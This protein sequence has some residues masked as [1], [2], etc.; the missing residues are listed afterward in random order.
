MVCRLK[1]LI[2]QLIA[3]SQWESFPPSKPP[4]SHTRVVSTQVDPPRNV[5][6]SLVFA[7][8]DFRSIP[9]INELY[10]GAI[11]ERNMRSVLSEL[12]PVS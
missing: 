2:R 3:P 5:A 1:T 6:P 12:V 4:A 10:A 8:E 11:D 7:D 9:Q